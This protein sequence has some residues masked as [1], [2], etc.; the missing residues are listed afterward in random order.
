MPSFGNLLP[1][2]EF[3]FNLETYDEAATEDVTAYYLTPV[4]NFGPSGLTG[5]VQAGQQA[6]VLTQDQRSLLTWVEKA[7][8][9]ARGSYIIYG[10]DYGTDFAAN[11]G[12]QTLSELRAGLQEDLSRCLLIHPLITDVNEA[13]LELLDTDSALLTFTIYDKLAGETRLA[14]TI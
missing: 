3:L 14:V 8:R 11:L 10:A 6:L 7:L 12:S 4:F 5:Y 9:T 1:D 13:T 2:Q